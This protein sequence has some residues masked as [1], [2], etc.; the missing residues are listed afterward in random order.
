VDRAVYNNADGKE[1]WML[2][3]FVSNWI[4]DTE[5]EVIQELHRSPRLGGGTTELWIES[6]GR[7]VRKPGAPIRVRRY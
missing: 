2:T 1:G 5:V 6:D 4:S 3:V 7:W